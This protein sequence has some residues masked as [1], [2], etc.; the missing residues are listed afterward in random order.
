MIF[1]IA[2]IFLTSKHWHCTQCSCAA[3]LQAPIWL[4]CSVREPLQW[5]QPERKWGWLCCWKWHP[6]TQWHRRITHQSQQK[7]SSRTEVWHL[8]YLTGPCWWQKTWGTVSTQP[9]HTVQFNTTLRS[10]SGG[11]RW[12]LQG[13]VH[14]SYWWQTPYTSGSEKTPLLKHDRSAHT[15]PGSIQCSTEEVHS[16]EE[17]EIS[18]FLANA[19]LI[20]VSD[21]K[22]EH[23]RFQESRG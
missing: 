11:L 19:G 2:V 16:W 4:L 12:V 9:W 15:T 14:E 10:R 8:L 18:F 13:V 17:R 3:A 5:L 23:L 20:A 1:P 21:C 22:T 6:Q 7:L